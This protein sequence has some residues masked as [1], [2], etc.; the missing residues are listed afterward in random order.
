M[1][2]IVYMTTAG[3]WASA[4]ADDAD[5]STTLL[6]IALGTDPDADGVLLRGT[7]TL[8]HDVGN[9]QGVPLYVSDGTAGQ[10]TAVIPDTS[11]DI[12]RI[13]GYNL[14][15]NDEIWFNPDN[16]WVEIS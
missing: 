8:D 14:G 15:D 10:A 16:T 3:Q 9:N 13:I 2:D 6:G 5:T 4:Q 7:Y 1:G 12:V 11:G